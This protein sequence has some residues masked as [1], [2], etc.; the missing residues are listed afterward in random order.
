[1]PIATP[2]ALRRRHRLRGT[3]AK[4]VVADR[5][6]RAWSQRHLPQHEDGGERGDE[7]GDHRG[8]SGE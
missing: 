3:T 4:C 6:A 8:G 1:M 2:P 5:V 7:E